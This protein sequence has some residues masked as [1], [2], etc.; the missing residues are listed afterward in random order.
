MEFDRIDLKPLS[1]RILFSLYGESKVKT[2]EIANKLFESVRACDAA[3]TKSL[4]RY[5]FVLRNYELTRL[6]KRSFA[7]ITITEHGRKYV[8]Y[9]LLSPEKSKVMGIYKITSPSGKVYIGQS[10]NCYNRWRSHIQKTFNGAS[11]EYEYPLYR[12]FRKY[13]VENFTFEVLEIIENEAELNDAET[14]WILEYNSCENGYNQLRAGETTPFGKFGEENFNSRFTE[15]EVINIRMRWAAK[16]ETTTEIYQDYKD[17]FPR[18]SVQNIYLYKVWPHILPELNTKENHEWHAN[19]L[20]GCV[21]IGENH[22]GAVLTE[23]DVIEI[24]LNKFLGKQRKEIL[25]LYPTISPNTI[26]SVLYNKSWK[27]ITQEVIQQE[28]IK[29]LSEEEKK[30]N[31]N[32]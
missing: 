17:R 27:H 29:R 4:V 25:S 32:D 8:E 26:D 28:I 12:S 10:K 3:I 20:R 6:M 2:E 15:E 24:R 5:G 11:P 1:K 7:Y 18:V 16:K 31:K 21:G 9:L 13:G 19:Q 30:G 23:Q 14:N 22:P